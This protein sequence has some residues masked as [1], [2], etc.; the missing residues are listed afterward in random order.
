MSAKDAGQ[1]AIVL[2]PALPEFGRVAFEERCRPA[3]TE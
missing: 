1:M 2:D 3:A